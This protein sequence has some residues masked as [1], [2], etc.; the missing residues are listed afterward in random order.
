MDFFNEYK[1]HSSIQ[2]DQKISGKKIISKL[3]NTKTNGNKFLKV[4]S[5][6]DFLIHKSTK[7]LWKISQDGVSIVP[8]FD[9]DVLTQDSL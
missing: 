2:M 6:S 3:K 1:W 8:V 9:D 5:Q 4:A 7:A